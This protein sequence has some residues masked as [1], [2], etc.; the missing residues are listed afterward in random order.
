MVAAVAVIVLVFVATKGHNS[1]TPGQLPG[2]ASAN[3]IPEE[4][5]T[6]ATE[7]ETATTPTVE[8]T[9]VEQLLNEYTQDY[10][11]EDL[12]ALKGLFA[13]SLER[14]DGTK[15]PE[16]L[17]TA[18]E[19]YEHQFSELRSPT[20][21]LSE[22]TIEPGTGE[23]TAHAKYS[24]TSQ[25]GTVTGSIIFHLVEQAEKLAIDKLTIEPAK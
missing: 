4:T 12:E 25:N 17:N 14:Q 5:S 19:T 10:S 2:V 13:E 16:D 21:S 11:N 3:P 9:Q 20:Y 23:A 18:L 7:T 8:S 1:D 15:T 22:Q 6:E 24:I